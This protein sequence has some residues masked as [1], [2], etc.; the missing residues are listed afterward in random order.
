MWQRKVLASPISACRRMRH[1]GGFALEEA[2]GRVEVPC[3][4]FGTGAGTF[5]Y[6]GEPGAAHPMSPHWGQAHL[7]A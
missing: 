1:E 6:Q 4:G 5:Q 2:E 3:V 7:F